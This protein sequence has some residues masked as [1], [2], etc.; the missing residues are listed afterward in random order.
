MTAAV[1]GVY[2]PRKC[3]LRYVLCACTGAGT[4]WQPGV[5]NTLREPA[6]GR[7]AA[8]CVLQDVVLQGAKGAAAH[9]RPFSVTGMDVAGGLAA[10]QHWRLTGVDKLEIF[11]GRHCQPLSATASC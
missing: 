2:P 3:M 9:L 10:I 7:S 8:G 4:R 6:A 11:N 1:A 5:A